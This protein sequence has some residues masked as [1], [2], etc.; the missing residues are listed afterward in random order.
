MASISSRP[1]WVNYIRCLAAS[2]LSPTFDNNF[3]N[4]WLTYSSQLDDRNLFKATTM[5]TVAGVFGTSVAMETTE[6]A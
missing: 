4:R 5:S 6:N 1:E 3:Q 2:P